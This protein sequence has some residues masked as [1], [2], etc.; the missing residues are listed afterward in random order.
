VPRPTVSDVAQLVGVSPSTVSRALS[1]DSGRVASGTRAQIIAAAREIGYT[2][3]RA[4]RELV[5]GRS[6]SIGIVIPDT[7]NPYFA[8]I[9]K[10]VQI[11][12]QQQ[13]LSVVV[14]D[15]DEDPRAELSLASRLVE[16]VDGLILC[17]SRMSDENVQ[18]IAEQAPVVLVNRQLGDIPSVSMDEAKIMRLA[19]EHLYAL[20][21]RHIA[22]VRGPDSSWTNTQRRKAIGVIAPSLDGVMVSELGPYRPAFNSGVQSVDLA[23]ARGASALITCNDLVA[24]GAMARLRQRG[25]PVPERISIVGIDDSP[26]A[27]LALPALTSVHTPQVRLGRSATDLMVDVLSRSHPAAVVDSLNIELRIRESTAPALATDRPARPQSRNDDA[28]AEHD[29]ESPGVLASTP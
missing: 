5:T 28:V 22:Y 10:G 26:T 7:Q 9:L 12:S 1:S 13:E 2:P 17:S 3:N 27:R 4:A 29:D 11:S 16:Q 23:L 19:I 8:A 15:C 25:I 21:H 20:D 18:L 14:A 6:N 24:M